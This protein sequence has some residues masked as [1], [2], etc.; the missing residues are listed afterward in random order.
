[1]SISSQSATA[2]PQL[3]SGFAVPEQQQQA[4][5]PAP[6]QHG[7]Q[8]HERMQ[9]KLQAWQVQNPGASTDAFFAQLRAEHLGGPG[10]HGGAGGWSPAGRA[11]HEA[12]IKTDYSQFIAANPNGSVE[13]FAQAQL[14]QRQQ[15]MAARGIELPQAAEGDFLQRMVGHIQQVL[16]TGV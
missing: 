8:M 9:A 14:A 10:G 7:G 4:G 12:A 1:M 16:G 15:R 5:F 11:Q 6:G 3:A 13:Q 2:L